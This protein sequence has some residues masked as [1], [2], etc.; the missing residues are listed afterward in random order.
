MLSIEDAIDILIKNDEWPAHASKICPILYED[1]IKHRLTKGR[2]V[3]WEQ[4]APEELKYSKFKLLL[5]NIQYFPNISDR[6]HANTLHYLYADDFP[7]VKYIYHT[8]EREYFG[9]Q[10]SREKGRNRSISP[11]LMYQLLVQIPKGSKFTLL[12][13]PP[14]KYADKASISINW[15][16]FPFDISSTESAKKT[17]SKKKSEITITR[18]EFDEEFKKF[19]GFVIIKVPNNYQVLIILMSSSNS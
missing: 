10:V 15:K 18:D 1:V 7:L 8:N 11:S 9:I 17:K 19:A 2:G 13:V 6:M 16:D 5:N 14:P 12:Y 3:I 4:R